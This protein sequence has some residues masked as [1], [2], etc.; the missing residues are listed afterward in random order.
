MVE[1]EDKKDGRRTTVLLD[2]NNVEQSRRS[3]YEKEK[4]ELEI[5][6]SHEEIYTQK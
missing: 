3:E 5:Q 2:E 1:K 6:F 4:E